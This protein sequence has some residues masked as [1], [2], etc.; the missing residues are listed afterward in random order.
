MCTTDRVPVGRVTVCDKIVGEAA[1]KSQAELPYAV[2][3]MKDGG[4]AV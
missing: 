1:L 4:E 3:D 2:R